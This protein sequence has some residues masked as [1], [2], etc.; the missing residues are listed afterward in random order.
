MGNDLGRNQFNYRRRFSYRVPLVAH[1]DKKKA[2]FLR[3]QQ[4]GRVGFLSEQHAE[5]LRVHIVFRSN[6]AA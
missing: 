6:H 5:F 1:A 4:Q 2:V 3:Q